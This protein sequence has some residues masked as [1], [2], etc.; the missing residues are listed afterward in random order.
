MQQ[1][2]PSLRSVDLMMV[3]YEHGKATPSARQMARSFPRLERLR[4]R[5][6]EQPDLKD[7][8]EMKHLRSLVLVD[9]NGIQPSDLQTLPL[10]SELRQ[11][12][13]QSYKCDGSLL[14]RLPPNLIELVWHQPLK[15]EH[16]ATLP[17]GLRK[18]RCCGSVHISALQLL[19]EKYPMLD[20][21]LDD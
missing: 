2:W 19:D 13:L 5:D 17:P 7:L 9:G 12:E 16:V 15:K 3:D 6:W 1:E 20:I 10:L 18:L 21:E 4:L 14:S 8:P 11:L